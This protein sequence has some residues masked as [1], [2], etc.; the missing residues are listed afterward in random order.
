MSSDR[1]SQISARSYSNSMNPISASSACKASRESWNGCIC[2]RMHWRRK[3]RN[4]VLLEF[5]QALADLVA[6]PDLC[7]QARADPHVL[8]RR[9][10]LSAREHQRLVD[11]INQPG[12][13]L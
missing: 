11:M 12:M 5:Q 10:D 9:Y 2:W 13:A 6:S 8:Q 7:R 4:T 3:R 1:G